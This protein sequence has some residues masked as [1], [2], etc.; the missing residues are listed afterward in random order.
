MSNGFCR[1]TV[2]SLLLSLSVISCKHRLEGLTDPGNGNA[3]GGNNGGTP[4]TTCD[5]TKIYFLQQVLPILI[6]NCA[7]S[8][9]H[10]NASHQEGVILNSY[11][12]IMSTAG[13]RPGRPENSELYERITDTDPDDQMPRPPMNPLTQQQ[14]QV[15]YQW[16]IQGAQ[17]LSCQNL[18]DSNNFSYSGAIKT[19]VSNK[20][21]GCHS[22]V[23]AQG[24]VDLS[25]YNGLKAKITDG[26]LW[27]AINHQPGFS[28]M[29][30][31]GTKLSDCEL[32]CVKKWIESGSPNN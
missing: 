21:Q 20:C 10:D 11:E 7:M 26:R 18:C 5:P 31:N 23:T 25:T 9:C 30:R 28:P 13:V 17:N 1:V 27:G 12:Q 32:T 4:S 29:P 6:S 15:I 22:G 14:K 24:G 2:L 3:G 8:N 16:I 19:L